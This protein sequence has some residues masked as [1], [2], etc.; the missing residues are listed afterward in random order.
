VGMA[1]AVCLKNRS[2]FMNLLQLQISM[3][4]YHS[5]WL[6]C[7]FFDVLFKFQRLC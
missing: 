2:K 6:V 1:A 7:I 5:S 3:F 4:T